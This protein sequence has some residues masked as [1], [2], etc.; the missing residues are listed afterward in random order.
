[1]DRHKRAIQSVDIARRRVDL[2]VH[3]RCDQKDVG[4]TPSTYIAT[5]DP[6]PFPTPTIILCPVM[7]SPFLP[8][9]FQAL[10]P[11]APSL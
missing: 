4:L 10:S 3:R 6:V 8:A 11:V 1:M 2:G 5:P 9:K 7:V